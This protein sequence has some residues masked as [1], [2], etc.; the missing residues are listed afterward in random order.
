MNSLWYTVWKNRY[1]GE[2]KYFGALLFRHHKH[3]CIVM[4][5]F[6]SGPSGKE[7][8]CQCRRLKR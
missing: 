3:N 4:K 7:P 1:R 5:G 8:I 6:P 2:I